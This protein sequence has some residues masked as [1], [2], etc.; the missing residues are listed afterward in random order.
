MLILEI[1][2]KTEEQKINNNKI[3]ASSCPRREV[4][5]SVSSIDIVSSGCIDYVGGLLIY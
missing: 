4:V 5:L 1:R 3:I 2:E